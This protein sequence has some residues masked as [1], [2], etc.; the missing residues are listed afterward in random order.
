MKESKEG[1]HEV[2]N[3]N[4]PISLLPILSKL[5]ERVAHGQFNKYL[6]EKCRLT[7]HQSE[8]RKHNS[9]EMFLSLFVTD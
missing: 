4:R 7:S 5:A 2:A 6:T 9:T 8:N 1:D 3:N